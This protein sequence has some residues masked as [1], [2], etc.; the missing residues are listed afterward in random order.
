MCHW[1]GSW[2][3]LVA[4]WGSLTPFESQL[5]LNARIEEWETESIDFLRRSPRLTSLFEKIAASCCEGL[6]HLAKLEE[7]D[8][9]DPTCVE[10][11]AS[12]LAPVRRSGRTSALPYPPS[13]LIQT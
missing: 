13:G 11:P 5:G 3:L 4:R 9:G 6:S 7:V 2:T 10:P 8:A 1:A 12:I